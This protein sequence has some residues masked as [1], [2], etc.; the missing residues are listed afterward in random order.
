MKNHTIILSLLVF[1]STILSC[2]KSEVPITRNQD[3][4]YIEVNKTLNKTDK[5]SYDF[6]KNG[7]DDLKLSFNLVEEEDNT[8]TN[9]SIS[10]P[11]NN[12]FN[13]DVA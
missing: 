7:I 6:D 9:L 2:T 11:N 13:F 1:L 3:I 5:F 10:I 12:P 4:Q 8:M